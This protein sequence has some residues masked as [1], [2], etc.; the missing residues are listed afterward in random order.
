MMTPGPSVLA[1]VLRGIYSRFPSLF[2]LNKEEEL[3]ARALAGESETL[4][5]CFSRAIIDKD[6]NYLSYADLKDSATGSVLIGT[7][8]RLF[9]L[10]NGVA[11]QVLNSQ[12]QW[13]TQVQYTEN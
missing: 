3:V 5:S 12:G 10:A 4:A 6:G 11:I 7:K 2:G 13:I 1:T 8:A 9:P